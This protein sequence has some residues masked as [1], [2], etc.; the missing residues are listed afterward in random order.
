MYHSSEMQT[1][2]L[3]IATLLGT[4]QPEHCSTRPVR[5]LNN[6]VASSSQVVAWH[7][8]SATLA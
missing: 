2:T 4:G 1:P 8:A 3:A 6:M 5:E 7:T